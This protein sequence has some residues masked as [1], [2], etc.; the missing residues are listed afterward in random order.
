MPHSAH[1]QLFLA[2]DPFLLNFH[3]QHDGQLVVKEDPDHFLI[4]LTHADQNHDV[5]LSSQT[6]SNTSSP[7]KHRVLNT[8][9]RLVQVSA[10]AP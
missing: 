6:I 9:E 3:S 8:P 7:S 1:R 2:D 10:V 4:D 5:V